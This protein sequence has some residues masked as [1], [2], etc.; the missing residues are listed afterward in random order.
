[1]KKEENY[2]YFETFVKKND[3][4]N[5][6]F[7]EDNTKIKKIFETYKNYINCYSE[8]EDTLKIYYDKNFKTN[9]DNNLD[10][11]FNFILNKFVNQLNKIND[12]KIINIEKCIQK[13]I[14]N[15]KI[16]FSKFGKPMR[17][18]LTNL[19]N[20]PPISNILYILGRKN[21]FL[22]LNNYINNKT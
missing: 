5:F 8:L 7:N 18:V 2:Q 14:E 15:N 1:M 9:L 12:W 20:G 19:N 10:V 16:K 17:S 3:I 6:F 4:F 21:T 13:F 11:N 22:R